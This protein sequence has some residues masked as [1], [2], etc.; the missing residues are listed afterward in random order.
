MGIEIRNM[1]KDDEYYVGT[2]THVNENNIEREMSAR[3]RIPWLRSMEKHGLVVKV[4]LLDGVHAGFLYIMPIEINP[5]DIQG[6]DL[7]IFPCLVSQSKFAR[8]SIGKQLIKAA[9][10][11]TYNKK[12][13][14][15]ATIGYFWDFWFMPAEYFT[16]LGF[17]VAAKRGIEAILWKK[18]DKTAEVP[19]FRTENYH[20]KSIEGKVVIDLFWSTF[21]LTSDVEAQRV[22]E[23]ASEFGEE[24]ILNEYSADDQSVLQKHGIS[25]R[26][27]INGN[28]IEVGPEI[29]KDRLRNEIKEAMIKMK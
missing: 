24:V 1:T 27:Y 6:K 29:E 8:Q 17:Q 22:R 4:A 28:M 9:E 13:K 16:K 20:F 2:C 23:V 18:F 3:R 26:I 25:R 21:C 19:E 12:R 7:L 15:I 5:W 10:Q 14:G 11:E